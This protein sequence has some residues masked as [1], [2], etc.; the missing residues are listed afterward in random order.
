MI[1]TR[2]RVRQLRRWI[3]PEVVIVGLAPP[4]FTRDL[5]EFRLPDPLQVEEVLRAE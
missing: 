3:R 5:H 1:D 2:I 4:V